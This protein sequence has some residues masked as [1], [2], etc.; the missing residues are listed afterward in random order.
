VGNAVDACVEDPDD[1]KQHTVT[2]STRRVGDDRIR[3]AVA[4]T[5]MGMDQP[6][7]DKLFTSFFSTKGSRGTGLGLMV[8]HKLVTEHGGDISVSSQPGTGTTVTM[9]L[10]HRGRETNP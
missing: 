2:V 1:G 4:D 10:P 6:T 5:G 8:T 9:T 7:Q 3:F